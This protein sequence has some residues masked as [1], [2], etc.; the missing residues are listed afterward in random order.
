MG[1]D[2]ASVATIVCRLLR[3]LAVPSECVVA[4]ARRVVGRGGPGLTVATR[5]P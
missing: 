4:R 2:E 1:P 3:K 5:P